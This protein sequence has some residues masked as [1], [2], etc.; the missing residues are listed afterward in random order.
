MIKILVNYWS[1]ENKFESKHITVNMDEYEEN[2]AITVINAILKQIT[3]VDTVYEYFID[4]EYWT[5]LVDI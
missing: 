3:D 2:E 1:V 5:I 4:E